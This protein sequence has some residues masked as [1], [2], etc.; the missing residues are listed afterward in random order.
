VV[1]PIFPPILVLPILP[2]IFPAVLES[3][4]SSKWWIRES[5]LISLFFPPSIIGFSEISRVFLGF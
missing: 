3:F 2:P 4:V 5:L 1:L